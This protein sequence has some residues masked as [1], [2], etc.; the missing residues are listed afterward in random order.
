[1]AT[2]EDS[3][4]TYSQLPI[5]LDQTTKRIHAT[6]TS[7]GPADLESAINLVNELHDQFKKLETPNG[8]PAAPLP[9]NPQRG[10]Q[11]NKLREAAGQA[12]T[13]KNYAD[14]VRNLGFAIDM[15]AQRPD[16]EPVGL[17]REELAA[18]YLARA[19]MYAE[20]REWVDAYHDA[21]SSA[22]C[23]KGP[24]VTPQGQ[25]IAGNPKAFLIGGKALLEMGRTD[26]AVQWLEKAIEVEGTQQDDS[27]HLI[28]MLQEAKEKQKSE[29]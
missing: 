11:I 12:A 1:M 6:S 19:A 10:H 21:M 13:K 15:A 18:C 29:E 26:E 2:A 5:H 23:K 14:A 8:V 24:T 17:K 4:N 20:Q 7:A 28:Q 9:I 3:F 16:W 25:K 22:E 27:K